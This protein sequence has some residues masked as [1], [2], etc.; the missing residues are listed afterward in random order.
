MGHPIT[1]LATHFPAVSHTFIADEIEALRRVGVEVVTISINPVSESS[2]AVGGGREHF[3]TTYLKA[4]PRWRVL[5]E[6][7]ST[8]MRHPSVLTIPLHHRRGGLRSVLRRYL[9]LA[10]AIIV[11]R[12]M[13][14]AGSHHLHAHLGQAPA[15]VA[16][17]ATEV[18]RRHRTGRTNTWSVTIHGWHEFVGEREAMLREK[19]AAADFVACVSDFTR[20]QLYRIADTGDHAK[21]HVVRCGIDL[22][23]FTRRL[24]EPSNTPPRVAI[25]ARVAPEKGHLVLVDA[26]AMLRERGLDVVVD[27]VGPEIDGHGDVVRRHAATNG[28]NDALVWHGPLSPAA[29][30]AVLATSDVFCLPTF[31]EGL[32]VVIMEAMASG[33]PVLTTYIS[34]IPELA[35]DHNNALVVPAARADLLADGLAEMLTDSALRNRLVDAAAA[36]VRE[37]HD[38]DRNV[39]ALARLF[40]HHVKAPQ[41]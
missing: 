36:S 20:A 10:E 17:Y 26:I 30:A 14:K 19:V 7:A 11:Y 34:G 15:T 22:S 35:I 31:A 12:V 33:V 1:Y 39:L 13:N 8:T 18:A 24:A 5:A 40:G 28:T 25:V 27:V 3:A 41:P 21:I 37:Q 32:P 23:R 38:V 6:V 2:I 9:Q 29:V 4:L 16:W